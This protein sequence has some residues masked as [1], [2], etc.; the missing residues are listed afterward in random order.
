MHR[1]FRSHLE[2]HPEKYI[3]PNPVKQV[4]EIGVLKP[5]ITGMEVHEYPNEHVI[6]LQGENLWF[7]Y[8]ICIDEKG[9]NQRDVC[10]PADSTT[11]FEIEFHVTDTVDVCSTLCSG[12]QVKIALFT[13][14]AK[15]IRQS[16]D[17]KR[18]IASLH[19]LACSNTVHVYNMYTCVSTGTTCVFIEA[20]S[21][22][23]AHTY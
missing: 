18:V 17:T 19:I 12:K 7:S 14:F 4:A 13:H 15:P 22:C 9:D 5:K 8:K 3:K 1:I 10:T 6:V 21:A 23:Q 16:M 20:N 2:K 11:R